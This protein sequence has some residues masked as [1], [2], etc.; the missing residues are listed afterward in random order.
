MDCLNTKFSKVHEKLHTWVEIHSFSSLSWD[1]HQG[2]F[3]EQTEKLVKLTLCHQELMQKRPSLG[4]FCV[5]SIIQRLNCNKPR[6]TVF[7][8]C[9]NE[10]Q[11]H[12][13]IQ[14]AVCLRAVPKP[15]VKPALHT[16]RSRASS[17]KWQYPLLS[18]RSS[19]SSLRL[20]PRL[21]VTSI[22][23]ASSPHSAI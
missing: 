1:I 18:L 2:G 11:I 3:K 17:F 15:L 22:P 14:S 19:S 23:K 4:T 21:P 20:L 16:V 9:C 7:I 10:C 12:S 5:H 6:H 8:Y 13:F